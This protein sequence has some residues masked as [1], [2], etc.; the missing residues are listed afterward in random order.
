MLFRWVRS[1]TPPNDSTN[2][3]DGIV[4]ILN[5]GGVLGG[6]RIEV[7]FSLHTVGSAQF[8]NRGWRA[9]H[10]LIRA[11]KHD[12]S[13]E[14]VLWI[15]LGDAAVSNVVVPSVFFSRTQASWGVSPSR[16]PVALTS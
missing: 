14:L 7:A 15:D 6:E 12:L 13:H 11:T 4:A 5:D 2:S 10:S 16:L 1:S 8:E 3:A 9:C